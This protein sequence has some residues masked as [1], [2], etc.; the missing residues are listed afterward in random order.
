[1]RSRRLLQGYGT[2]AHSRSGLT[3][4][5]ATVVLV[6]TAALGVWL[7]SSTTGAQTVTA[8]ETVTSRHPQTSSAAVRP[9]TGQQQVPGSSAS[10]ACNTQG[11]GT[12]GA[13]VDLP[14]G[15]QW[16]V[17]GDNVV[18]STPAGGPQVT[19]GAVARCFAHDATGA[20]VAAIRIPLA[21]GTAGADTW[22][23][24]VDAGLMPGAGTD[25]VVAIAQQAY[26]A[27]GAGGT[28]QN[29]APVAGFKFIAYSPAQAVVAVVFRSPTG[30]L[31]V[32]DTVVEWSG[33]DWQVQPGPDGQLGS[34][35]ALVASLVGYV[36]MGQP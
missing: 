17:L 28:G 21:I 5:G 18:P 34:P 8:K 22:R 4:A 1:M 2:R 14:T 32:S 36:I 11:D 26:S 3:L 7:L 15:L 12:T 19:Q 25:A 10:A 23:P 20:L 33:G 6:G 16:S 27:I 29:P 30:A 24:I 31:F 35:P 9:T 13:L